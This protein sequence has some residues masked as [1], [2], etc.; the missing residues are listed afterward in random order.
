M[1]TS[2]NMLAYRHSALFIW[3]QFR[4]VKQV[5]WLR[6][7]LPFKMICLPL[8]SWSC[9]KQEN[10]KQLHWRPLFLS[11]LL[12]LG[13]GKFGSVEGSW[14]RRTKHQSQDQHSI[15]LRCPW[16]AYR[17]CAVRLHYSLRSEHT[18]C[19]LPW[20]CPHTHNKQHCQQ[21]LNS[22]SRPW[23]AAVRLLYLW[24]FLLL[25]EQSFDYENLSVFFNHYDK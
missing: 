5:D 2:W 4:I 1:L 16:P 21:H 14:I 18:R 6:L 3:W 24:P 22:Y 23:D 13:M 17:S 10:L 25:R 19:T 8:P 20:L 12:K 9:F 7:F 11:Q 15:Y